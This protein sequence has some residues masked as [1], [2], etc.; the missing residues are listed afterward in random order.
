MLDP[1]DLLGVVRSD[2]RFLADEWDGGVDDDSL[3][4]S[5]PVL[6]RLI[7]DG[8]LQRAWK[9]AGFTKQPCLMAHCLETRLS[10]VALD[11]IDLA[12]AGGAHHRGMRFAGM[13]VENVPAR[14]QPQG[15]PSGDPPTRV[16][17]LREFVDAPGMVIRGKQVARRTVI[18]YV[19]NKL[20]GAH[21]DARRGNSDEELLFASLDR[22]GRDKAF[23][24]LDRPIAFYELLS[25]GQAIAGST[26]IN[27]LVTG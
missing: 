22:V 11:R 12:S 23:T 21:H 17:A 10:G 13:L 15:T 6:R 25:I 4:R 27:R 3:R 8:E 9:A 14:G 5:S 19:A 20:G 18:K 2:L 26:E 24:L 7:V 16:F 1:D